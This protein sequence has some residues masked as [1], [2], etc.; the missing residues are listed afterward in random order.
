MNK[1]TKESILEYLK[2]MKFK[3]ALFGVS[4]SDALL[5]MRELHQMYQ[6]L[7]QEQRPAAEKESMY[8]EKVAAVAKA[9]VDMQEQTGQITA[10]AQKQA[11]D[12]LADA[13]KKADEILRAAEQSAQT[14]VSRHKRELEQVL[15]RQLSELK[16]ETAGSGSKPEPITGS[17]G[18]AL[19]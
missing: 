13:R 4:R 16:K 17:M 15:E 14:L 12:I 11:E 9:F 19:P 2:S 8:E 10:G 3:R 1:V 7:L 5:K 6:Q 18:H